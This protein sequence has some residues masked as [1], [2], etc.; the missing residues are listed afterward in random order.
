[1][2]PSQITGGHYFKKSDGAYAA[3][4][5]TSY[6]KSQNIALGGT[7]KLGGKSFHVIGFASSPLGGN[8]SDIY[9]TLST[10]QKLAGYSGPGEHDAGEG[11][12][13]GRRHGGEG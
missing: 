1:M 3:V 7:V 8:A 2:T 6:A 13:R 9:I 12:E 11:L 5:S 4:L 10:L